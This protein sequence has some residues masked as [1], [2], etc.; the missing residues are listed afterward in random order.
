MKAHLNPPHPGHRKLIA[1]FFVVLVSLAAACSS[2]TATPEHSP[3]PTAEPTPAIAPTAAPTVTS[4]SGTGSADLRRIDAEAFATLEEILA[5]LGPRES[6]TVQ[7]SAAAEYLKTNLQEL[8]YDVRIQTFSVENL[9]LAGLGLTLVAP[10]SSETQE[11]KAVPMVESGQGDVSGSLISVGLAMP[12]DI[13]KSGLD[14]RIALAKRGVITFQAKAENVFAAGA[15]GLVVYNNVF[16]EF[17]GVLATESE[18]PVISISRT[19]GETIEDLLAETDTEASINLV[20][21]D[22][23]SQNVIAE[24]KGSS[25]DV[26]VLGGH[27]D[28]VPEIS[29]ANDNAS[30]TAVLL[31]VAR[32]LSDSDL[33][34]TLKIV[35]FGSEELGL[36]GSKFYVQSLSEIEL[37][38]TK[39]MLNFDALGTGSGVSVFGDDNLV[40][41]L[42]EV[43]GQ[44]G[45]EI[46]VRRGLSGGSS[47]H[48]SFRDAGVPYAMF[49]GDDPSRIHTDND[50]I[51]FVQPEML[52]GAAA[53]TAA[54][55]ESPEFAALIKDR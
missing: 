54:L 32:L 34:F 15:I 27:Y 25:D 39:F 5:E 16:A 47:D 37:Q 3:T 6:T 10:G 9:S 40:E 13:P 14:G 41:I 28:T 55:L 7:E 1:I 48:A 29:G 53:A 19:D 23:P 17:R 51:E 42:Q 36:L 43:G 30:G 18:F 44:A 2:A 52:G 11:F 20:L 24:K 22:L 38:N 4:P 45:I 46:T 26:V 33:P 31:T 8:G 50:T 49:F 12:G 21:E 35:P